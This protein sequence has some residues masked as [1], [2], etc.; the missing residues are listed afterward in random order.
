MFSGTVIALMLGA[1]TSAWVYSQVM[2]R[3]G[4]NTK[5]SVIVAGVAFVMV[6]FMIWSIVTV[7]DQ[8]VG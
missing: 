1:G 4:N 3:T 2:R 6:F 7:I 5:S 8:N